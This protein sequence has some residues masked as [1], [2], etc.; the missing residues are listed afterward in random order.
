MFGAIG[1]I[2]VRR[3]WLVIIGWVVAAVA[4]IMTA[5][6][7][8]SVTNKEGPPPIVFCIGGGPS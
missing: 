2:V 7:L 5:P 1:R 3:P 6:S 8:G 4:I